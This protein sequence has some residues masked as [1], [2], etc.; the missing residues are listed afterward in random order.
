MLQLSPT[1]V[2]KYRH[3]IL[4][5]NP[6]DIEACEKKFI[7]E[8]IYGIKPTD[9]MTKGSA[10]HS[11][12]E[13]P[14]KY[15]IMDNRKIYCYECNKIKFT[16]DIIN[17][18]LKYVNREFPFEVW[19]SKEYDIG[20]EIIRIRGRVDQ[21]EGLEINEHKTCWG[22]FNYEQYFYS[23]QWRLYIDMLEAEKINYKVFRL[24]DGAKGINYKGCY[25]FSFDK[26][27]YLESYIKKVLSSF[28]DW[29]N[30]KDLRKYFEETYDKR[31]H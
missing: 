27:K 18:C 28:V 5:A 12:L 26:Y 8:I 31:N 22:S 23:M 24:Y 1:N 7:N 3:L 30:V 4:E 13:N 29:I 6:D 15:T 16:T 10:L 25:I 2:E 11:I 21:L 14:E 9:K 20:N 17:E 19:T